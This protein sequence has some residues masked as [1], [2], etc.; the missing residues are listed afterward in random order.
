MP[1][2]TLI[3]TAVNMLLLGCQLKLLFKLLALIN[4][5]L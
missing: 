5:T 2:E 4:S 1:K 3:H